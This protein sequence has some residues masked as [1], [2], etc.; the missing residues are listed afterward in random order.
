MHIYVGTSR[1][2]NISFDVCSGI[3]ITSVTSN[4]FDN[5][6]YPSQ[7]NNSSDLY[8]LTLL[9]RPDDTSLWEHAAESDVNV[10]SLTINILIDINGTC[11]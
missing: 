6:I 7:I 10:F 8:K 2:A 4:R 1:D 9:D 5:N 11:Q 3:R